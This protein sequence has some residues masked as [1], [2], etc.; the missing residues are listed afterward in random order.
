SLQ[1]AMKQSEAGA[2][3]EESQQAL[4]LAMLGLM[5]QLSFEAAQVRFE[6]ASITKR[7]LDYAGSQQNMSGKQMAD[8][9]KAMTPIMLAQLNIPELQN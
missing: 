9:L 8:S 7:A 5:Q 6:D 4:G 1:D 2:N 3:K